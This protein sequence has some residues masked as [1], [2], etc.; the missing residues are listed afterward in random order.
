MGPSGQEDPEGSGQRWG[1][2]RA[3]HSPPLEGDASWGQSSG[4]SWG[5]GWR[6]GRP[7]PLTSSSALWIVACATGC[8]C[9][10]PH[11]P[12]H[13]TPGGCRT[14]WSGSQGPPH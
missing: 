2:L 3:G 14:G 5:V 10:P 8:F 9:S 12:S 1:A 4:D 6:G 11:A 13:P 7:R